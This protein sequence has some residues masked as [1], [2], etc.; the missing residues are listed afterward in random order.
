MLKGHPQIFKQLLIISLVASLT[1]VVM[2]ARVRRPAMLAD[3]PSE[4]TN[5]RL[6]QTVNRVDCDGIALKDFLSELADRNEVSIV[7][8]W[9]ELGTLDI[10]PSTPIHLHLKKV[11]LA[12]VLDSLMLSV[13]GKRGWTYANH[14]NTFEINTEDAFKK[15]VSIETRAYDIQSL[16]AK[17]LKVDPQIDRLDEI[18]KLIT[19]AGRSNQLER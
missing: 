9:D 4:L 6:E 13:N 2:G 1:V 16:L 3:E 10:E 18:Q 7:T 14:G 15:R 19:V 17:A 8:E 5:V 11:S 12:Q